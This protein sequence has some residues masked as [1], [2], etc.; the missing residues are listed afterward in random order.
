[1]EL[2]SGAVF[3]YCFS[4]WGQHNNCLNKYLP[5]PY[6]PS[7]AWRALTANK[8]LA[9]PPSICNP[10]LH[11]KIMITNNISTSAGQFKNTKKQNKMKTNIR[12]TPLSIRRGWRGWEEEGD[13]V[14]V[15]EKY[16]HILQITSFLIH[17]AISNRKKE[18]KRGKQIN[19][20]IISIWENV[21]RQNKKNIYNNPIWYGNR[22]QKN[23]LFHLLSLR[24]LVSLWVGSG[25][26]YILFG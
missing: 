11:S 26:R 7:L 21:F 15:K 14:W 3:Y 5:N 12:S 16:V 6:V 9:R 23:I 17:S 22:K 25:C 18:E 13:R 24:C 2:S 20:R 8:A 1:M 4:I 10:N 19:A